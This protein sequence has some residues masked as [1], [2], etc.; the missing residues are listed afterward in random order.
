MPFE[1]G[2]NHGKG[3]PKGSQNK[4]TVQIKDFLQSV[5]EHLEADLFDD[6]KELQPYDRVKVW[7]TIQEYLLPKLSRT[8]ISEEGDNK[9]TLTVNVVSP[10]PDYSALSIEELKFLESIAHKVKY[11][12]KPILTET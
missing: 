8:D 10:E 6:L 9:T 11:F 4:T 5:S 12:D 3:R 7:L 2:N 1:K